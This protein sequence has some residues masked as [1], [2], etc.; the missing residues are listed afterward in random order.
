MCMCTCVRYIFRIHVNTSKEYVHTN[1]N[2]KYI[3]ILKWK[4]NKAYFA[5]KLREAIIEKEDTSSL[6]KKCRPPTAFRVSRNQYML[7][8]KSKYFHY[9][10]QLD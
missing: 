2:L 9:N 1:S 4:S 3:P 7:T 5:I 8:L 6:L 10:I